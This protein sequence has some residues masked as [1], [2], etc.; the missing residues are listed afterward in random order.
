MLWKELFRFEEFN[1]IWVFGVYLIIEM[2]QYALLSFLMHEQHPLLLRRDKRQIDWVVIPW[3]VTQIF[4][5]T[6]F[7]TSR[8]S[9]SNWYSTLKIH[10]NNT[11]TVSW[12]F[13]VLSKQSS[14]SNHLTVLTSIFVFYS[15]KFHNDKCYFIFESENTTSEWDVQFYF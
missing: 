13:T 11:I 2:I 3:I 15:V 1:F 14:S 12:F 4:T 6:L 5:T 7:L 8:T 10:S 9:K